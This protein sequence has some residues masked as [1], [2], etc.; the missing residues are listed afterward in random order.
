MNRILVVEDENWVAME[1]AWLVQEA[2]YTVLGP[3]R[4]V[5]EARKTLGKTKVDLALL[6]VALRGET[7]F[8]LSRMLEGLDIPFIFVTGNPASLPA[9][10]SRRPLVPKPW[11]AP[12]LRSLILQVLGA[13]C[14]AA[15]T[16]RRLDG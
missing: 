2:G 14:S 9:E 1:L 13:P 11:R 7:V 3:E 10:Y 15:P 4:T 6:D 12:A 5:A 16:D 8:P